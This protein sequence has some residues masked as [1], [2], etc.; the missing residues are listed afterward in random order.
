MQRGDKE[1]GVERNPGHASSDSPVFAKTTLRVQSLMMEWQAGDHGTDAGTLSA[2]NQ[3]KKKPK[4]E[5]ELTLACS[6]SALA[7]KLIAKKDGPNRGRPFYNCASN[8]CKFFSWAGVAAAST[9]TTSYSAVQQQSK[10]ERSCRSHEVVEV[11]DDDLDRIASQSSQ[12]VTACL[13][14]LPRSR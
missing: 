8:R 13:P 4:L 9:A 7:R 6:C 2:E 5:F 10:T 14:P 12:H 11:V 3:A 1:G